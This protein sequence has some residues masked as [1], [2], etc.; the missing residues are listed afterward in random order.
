MQLTYRILQK[1]T[2]EKDSAMKNIIYPGIQTAIACS[3]LFASALH[4][5]D[6][7]VNYDTSW[8]YVY[9]GGKKPDSTIY[10]AIFNDVKPLANGTCICVGASADSLNPGQSLLVRLGANGK[11][12]Q[13]KLYT[14]NN[15]VHS[16]YNSQSTHSVFVAKNGDFILGGERWSAP[17]IMRTDSVGNL[18]WA[19]WYYDSTRGVLGSLLQGTGVV[20]CVRET[21]RG[22]IICAAGDYFTDAGYVYGS[23]K[24]DYAAVLLL[25]STGKVLGHGEAGGQPG[26]ASGGFEIEE[27][28]THN[29]ILSGN[30]S[31]L[32]MDSAVSHQIWEK[33]YTFS[34]S[35][36]G[37]EVN[38]ITRCKR[39]G[40]GTLIVAG[41]AYGIEDVLQRH[42]SNPLTI[43]L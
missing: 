1:T 29:F 36:V 23:T 31:I 35:G 4:A 12:I 30:Q 33:K 11:V 5:A 38:N 41:Q 20:N 42:V 32:Y 43:C 17:W 14:T 6:S 27:A 34:L 37:T 3:V 22:T 21:S 39:L 25:D 9:N 13:K 16:Y 28:S 19:T 7:T 15:A 10:G 2:Q 26:Y 40:N 18:K 8:T 24:N